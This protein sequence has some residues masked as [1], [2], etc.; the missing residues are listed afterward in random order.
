MSLA[1]LPRHWPSAPATLMLL[2]VAIAAC[3]RAPSADS[4]PVWSQADHHSTDDNRL[5]GAQ[6]PGPA[7]PGSAGAGAPKASDVDPLVELT[8]RQ[9]CT[10]C[11]GPMGRGDG[12]M[13]PMVQAP[14]LTAGDWQS[15]M[16]DAEMAALIKMGRNRM[17][18]FNLPDPVLAG[19]VARIRSLKAH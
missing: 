9:Q 12:Q 18:G 16:S 4:L 19:L 15:K 2:C 5:T 13:G 6:A 14:D 17:P 10:T 3:D 7:S 11:H 1:F 8:W